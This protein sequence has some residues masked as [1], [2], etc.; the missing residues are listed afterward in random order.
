MN[1]K[2][3]RR[4]AAVLVGLCLT[5]STAAAQKSGHIERGKYLF[6]AAGCLA[7]HTDVKN[8]GAPLAGGRELKTPFGVFYSPNITPD[9]QNGIGDWS[10]AD[11]IR[12]LR[13]GKNPDGVNYFPV[14]PYSSYTMMSDGDMLDIKAYMFSLPAVGAP[15]RPHQL[16]PLFS[17]RFMVGAWKAV[18]FN[19]GPMQPVAK[20]GKEWNRGAYLVEALGHCREC[21]TPRDRLGGFRQQMHL[22]GTKYG[23]EGEVTPNITPDKETGI[24]KW[25]DRDLKDLF[26]IG[27]MPDGD[28]V[29]GSMG[30]FVTNTS[31]KWTKEDVDSI[32]I[33]LRSIAPVRNKVK[34]DKA[35]SGD[36]W[37]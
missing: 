35:K 6:D 22:A 10:D 5:A 9:P 34:K 36:D 37:Q 1:G 32:I 13:H 31:S 20:K 4:L 25:P 16:S 27:L 11:F 12:A 30:E 19:E 18:N 7:C 15:N 26:S 28:F 23:P 17:S 29:G 3:T 24:G 8:K 33:Y 21:H 2:Y 14:F